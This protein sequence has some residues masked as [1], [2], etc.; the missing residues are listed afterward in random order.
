MLNRAVPLLTA[1]SCCGLAIAQVPAPTGSGPLDAPQ[2]GPRITDPGYHALRGATVHLGPG[3]TVQNATVIIQ[4]GLISAVRDR[5]TTVSYRAGELSRVAIDV[6]T[7]EAARRLEGMDARTW[8]YSGMHIYAGFIE[9]WFE[10]DA[11]SPDLSDPGAHW[12]IHVT[13]QRHALGSGGI[14][15]D[16]AESLRDLGFTAA[17]IAPT[18]TREASG[19]FGG[20]GAVVSLAD[21]GGNSSAASPTVYRADA[22][23]TMDFNTDGWGGELVYPTSQMGAIALIR[24]TFLDTQWQARQ[25]QAARNIARNALDTLID[26]AQLPVMFDT[27]HELELL[28]AHSIFEEF[29]DGPLSRVVLVGSGT[30]FRR[31]EALRETGASV[32]IPLRY[33]RKPDVSSV[34]K[35]DSVSLR[36]LMT[37]EQAPANASRVEQ[38]GITF[39]ITSSKLRSRSGFHERLRT[40][41]SHGLSPEQALASI[42][43]TP[44]ALL[45]VDDRLGSLGLGKAA[46]LVVASGNLFDPED[47]SYADAEIR[48]VW[49]EGV[50]YEISQNENAA[51]DGDWTLVVGEQ[52]DPVFTME[53][54]VEPGSD[55]SRSIELEYMSDAGEEVEVA[56]RQAEVTSTSVSFLVDVAESGDQGGV[57]ALSG[58]LAS[59]DKIVGSG[60]APDDSVFQWS[61]VREL[62]D[63]DDDENPGQ[64]SKPETSDVP[65]LPGYPFGP[66]AVDEMPEADHAVLRGGTVWTSAESGIIENG[67]VEIRDGR[68]V[69]VGRARQRTPAGARLID[70]TGKHLT[71]GLLDAHSHTGT[72]TFGTNEAGQAVTAEVRMGDTND[73]DHINW[74]RQLAAG[75]TTV[76]TLHGSANPIGGQNV[77]QKVRWGVSHPREMHLEGAKPGIKFALGEN[78]RQVNWGDRYRSRYP[79]S[80][81]GV[82][83]LMRDRFIAAREYASAKQAGEDPKPDLELE[84]LA[85]ILGNERLIHCHS[86]RQDEILMLA[87]IARDFDF[88][89]GSYQHALECYKVA[90]HVHDVSLGSSMFSDW[91][92][93]K[94]E[95]QDAIPHAGPIEWAVGGRVSYN[96]DSDELV[97]RMNTEAAKAVKYAKQLGIDLPADE[98]LK[99]V[100]IN[101]AIQLG[102]DDRVGSLEAGKDADLAVWSASPLS[103]YAVCEATYVDGAKLFSVEIDRAHNTQNTAERARII[104]KILASP[105]D[106]AQSDEDEAAEPEAPTSLRERLALDAWRKHLHEMHLTGTLDDLDPSRTQPG[107][108]GCNL[109]NFGIVH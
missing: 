40:A 44:A 102:I 32:V 51:F 38:A 74:Y 39:A 11:P 24:Q 89:I 35:A 26:H 37:W 64:D 108:C 79:Q 4:D 95:V 109:T 59:D 47:P 75:V 52:N 58:V 27:D 67:E 93:Y 76:N 17:A 88:T 101:P 90:E 57:Y 28:Q 96:S 25:R 100:T 69:Y 36:D 97:R 107:D 45:G 68:I 61:A 8:D 5:G 103:T 78:V 91:W 33:P 9:S 94:I 104:Q 92:A 42:T 63:D 2:N 22:F 98:A 83:S 6:A 60:R 18:T 106:D 29:E 12:S 72:W 99:F 48:D 56:G 53:L 13:P 70:V 41:I 62:D 21:S 55:G 46:S 20:L 43:T 49:V 16:D 23:H 30:E 14:S 1:I 87:E 84:A 82:D 77:I 65:D 80:R 19:L 3:V 34:G 66:F 7:A 54:E 105:N 71:P 31:L 85:E 50:R 10:V 15:A 81:M 86:Y 73:P